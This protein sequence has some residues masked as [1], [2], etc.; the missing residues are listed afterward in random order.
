[1][2]LVMRVSY[3]V[4][5]AVLSSLLLCL[6]SCSESKLA[7]M[8]SETP[9][10][11]MVKIAEGAF[12]DLLV[13]EHP[14]TNAQFRNF[15]ISSPAWLRSQ[16]AAVLVGENY[17]QHWL[18]DFEY[19]EGSANSP[20]TNVSWFAAREYARWAGRRLA[21]Q[22][23][24]ES[25]A[26]ASETVAD[27]S[28]EKLYQQ[29]ILDWYQR[30]IPE[31]PTAVRL[32]KPNY[33]QLFDMHGLIWEWVD[34]FNKPSTLMAGYGQTSD[35]TKLFCG[36][37]EIADSDSNDVASFRLSFRNSFIANQTYLNIGFRCVADAYVADC[38]LPLEPSSVTA[39]LPNESIYLTD[40]LWR[41][42]SGSERALSDFVGQVVV[43]VMIFTHCEYACPRTML[44]LKEIE[45]EIPAEQLGKVRWLLV[46]MDSE[47]DTPEVL[48]AYAE[49]NNLETSRWTLLHGDDFAVRGIAAALGVRYK[50]GLKGNFAHSNIITTLDSAGRIAHQLVGLGTESSPTVAAIKA[51]CQ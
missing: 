27:G 12:A 32:G 34:D 45:K 44:D 26:L 10:T 14:V 29:T 22:D 15:V 7:P 49:T 1:M 43:A 2:G 18:G 30:Q 41:D 51:E 24:W 3:L 37:V 16:A 17:L 21:T 50:K 48:Q 9:L 23:E 46:S 11:S 31:I 5:V 4:I 42:Q 19:P 40:G 20:V 36:N 47:R 28:Q 38:C 8:A 6:T 39:A 25:L 35:V 33:Y 13:E